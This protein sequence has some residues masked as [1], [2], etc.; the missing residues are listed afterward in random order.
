MV[1]SSK[2]GK[3]SPVSNMA[4]EKVAVITGVS[5]GIGAVA[6]AIG[7]MRPAIVLDTVE[8]RGSRPLLAPTT[9]T[10]PQAATLFLILLKPAAAA[11]VLWLF[12]DQ[13]KRIDRQ[14]LSGT[15]QRPVRHCSEQAPSGRPSI[16]FVEP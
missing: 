15:R 9:E 12:R 8:V 11:V 4:K 2:S 6:M 7:K 5:R 10:Y 3:A 16:G 13:H 1:T 14:K